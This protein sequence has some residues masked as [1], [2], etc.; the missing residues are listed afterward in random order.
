MRDEDVALSICRQ[1]MGG[2]YV[3]LVTGH[4]VGQLRLSDAQVAL[5][6]SMRPDGGVWPA[7]A[8]PVDQPLLVHVTAGSLFDRGLW[9]EAC[10]LLQIE[11]PVEPT[12]VLVLTED[13]ARALRLFASQ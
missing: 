5:L 9:A 13:H 4:V 1:I 3:D 6:Q 10:A 8:E 12:D 2:C 7:R 11:G